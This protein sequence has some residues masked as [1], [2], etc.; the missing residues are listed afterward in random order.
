[1]TFKPHFAANE[2]S[3]KMVLILQQISGSM[4]IPNYHLCF[5]QNLE[6]KTMNQQYK[7][8]RELCKKLLLDTYG[9]HWRWKVVKNHAVSLWTY[10]QRIS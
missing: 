8:L 4:L 1:M 7:C 9:F 6:K 10:K 5:L 2:N 3:N